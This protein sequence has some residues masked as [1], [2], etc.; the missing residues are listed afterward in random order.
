M[1]A[2]FNSARRWYLV[3]LIARAKITNRGAVFRTNHQ[4]F[5]YKVIDIGRV[6]VAYSN[7]TLQ[8]CFVEEILVQNT[9]D[10]TTVLPSQFGFFP[11]AQVALPL[12]GFRLILRS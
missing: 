7:D 6:D 4:M 11:S 12:S 9:K 8:G 1:R 3:F 2:V 10:L 5:E